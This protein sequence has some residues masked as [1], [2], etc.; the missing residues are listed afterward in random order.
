MVPVDPLEQSPEAATRDMVERAVGRVAGCCG[1]TTETWQHGRLVARVCSHPDLGE[2]LTAEPELPDSPMRAAARTLRPVRIQ[3][4]LI[5]VHWRPFSARALD[6]SLRSLVSVARPAGNDEIVT[7]TLYS[8]RPGGLGAVVPQADQ[9]LF[10]WTT[11]LAQ[12]TAFAGAQAEAR[13]LS[14]AIA[15]RELVEQ[16]KGMLMN[17][18]GCDADTAYQELVAAA[19][20]ARLRIADVARRMVE[21]RAAPPRSD[22]RPRTRRRS[23]AEAG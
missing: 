18:L 9:L 14:E 1:V 4:T 2:L 23:T 19:S 5:D 15:A 13:Q 12:A 16:A 7:C 8:L 11:T 20:R 6:L 21:H 3:D 22:V 10:E 17:A